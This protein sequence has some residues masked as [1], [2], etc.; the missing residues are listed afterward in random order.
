[1]G[2]SFLRVSVALTGM[3]VALS[4]IGAGACGGNVV[5]DAISTSASSGTLGAGGAGG[6]RGI[7]GND[8]ASTSS[9]FMTDVATSTVA[10]SVVSSTA[11]VSSVTSTGTGLSCSCPVA[12]MIAGSCGISN[13]ACLSI[14]QGLA[15]SQV[16]CVCNAGPGNC[17]S[18]LMCLASPFTAT[19][20][21]VGATSS[22]S[23]SLAT[24][25]SCAT[26]AAQGQC[27]AAYQ[28]CAATPECQALLVCNAKCGSSQSCLASCQAAH[29]TGGPAY[30]T[31]IDCSVCGTCAGDCA[32][33]AIST[34]YCAVEASDGG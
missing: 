24:C 4:A 6:S 23:G 3:S 10:T 19:A 8:Q 25:L 20:T 16:D 26:D 2:S 34:Y 15:Q 30:S 17:G 5:V 9:G 33:Q 29:P 31:L 18:A 22:S 7:G 27:R 11:S 28:A 13:A 1:M 32:G 14:C 21:G 12:C